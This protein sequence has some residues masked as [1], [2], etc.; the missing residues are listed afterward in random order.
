MRMHLQSHVAP[1]DRGL[2]EGGG[3]TPAAFMAAIARRSLLL[4]A[5][6]VL[7]S[8]VLLGVHAK[9]G[10]GGAECEP[11]VHDYCIIG[12]GPGGLQLGQLMLGAG[13]D[14]TV[15]DSQSHAGAFFRANPVHR[16]LI[17]LNKRYSG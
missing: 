13:M 17:S 8:P 11:A 9:A 6:V 16:T 10:E 2:Q 3:R 5:A 4:G 7:L 14:Y 15:F 1:L 12:A